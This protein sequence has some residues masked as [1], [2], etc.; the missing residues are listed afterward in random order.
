MRLCVTHKKYCDHCDP[1]LVCCDPVRPKYLR[2]FAPSKT[3]MLRLCATQKKVCYDHCD[4]KWVC[5]DFVWPKYLRDFGQFKTDMK[6]LCAT[7]DST[8]F[9]HSIRSTV[10][11]CDENRTPFG[12]VNLRRKS[13]SVRP[14]RSNHQSNTSARARQKIT[15]VFCFWLK[16][17]PMHF[18]LVASRSFSSS[19]VSLNWFFFIFARIS[20]SRLFTVVSSVESLISAVLSPSASDASSIVV[21]VN[22]KQ[23]I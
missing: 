3:D 15:E 7:Y 16:W 21:S 17:V 12:R 2:D 10:I 1:K 20:S 5:C 11:I 14:C 23:V 9:Y 13:D 22:S 4:L 6:R 18:L 8:Y 19:V